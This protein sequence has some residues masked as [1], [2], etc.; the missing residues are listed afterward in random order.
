MALDLF[1]S[2]ELAAF[3]LVL[4][5]SMLIFYSVIRL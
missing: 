3:Y 1:L 4:E 5:V 2:I